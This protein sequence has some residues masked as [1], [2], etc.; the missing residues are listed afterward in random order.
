MN[1]CVF[2][3]EWFTYNMIIRFKLLQEGVILSFILY[4]IEQHFI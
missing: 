2:V 3:Y 4:I 1:E